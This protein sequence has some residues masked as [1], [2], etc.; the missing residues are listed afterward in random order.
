[1]TIIKSAVTTSAR[2]RW[3]QLAPHT[4]ILGDMAAI[5]AAF[6]L[7]RLSHAFYYHLNSGWVLLHWWGRHAQINQLLFLVLSISGI[8]AFAFKGHYSRRKAFWDETG[9][10]LGVFILL[11]ALNATIAFAG[12]W[13]MSRL[14]LF[15]TWVLV[16]G[17]LPMTRWLLRLTLQGLGAWTRPVVIIGCG[18]NAAEAIRALNSEPMLGYSIQRVLVP[19]GCS[20]AAGSLPTHAPIEALG[21]DPLATLAH[22]G[23]PHVVLA[24][25]MDQWE[26]QERLVRSLGLRYSNLTIA[27]P[28]RGLPLFGME[29]MHFFS[30]EVLMLRVRD[31]LARLSPRI[32]KRLFDLVAASLLVVV[33][34]PLLL[35]IA[36]RIRSE[37]G[38]PVFFI[39]ERVGRRG[40]Q[41]GCLKFRSMVMDAEDRLKRY[42]H[43]HPELAAE[44]AINF[45]I[46]NDPRVTRIG[47]FLR[48]GSLDEL[49]QLFNVLRGDMSLVGPRPLLERELDRYGENICLY[50]LVHPGITGLWQV[51]GRSETTFDER[52]QLDAWY[53]KN[54]TLW[55]DIVIL[56]RTVKVVSRREGAY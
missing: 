44:Y 30:H 49:P 1:M 26:A 8:M 35:Y 29:V 4:L 10:I 12:K 18:Q 36:W 46:R 41:F 45:K 16:L 40:R 54:W 52:A 14:W 33:L 38:G 22:L 27:P 5:L 32:T 37:D 47:K 19:G 50:R 39:Q 20:P 43:S 28:L 53:V 15:S 23:K 34:S 3:S 6:Y 9:E 48:R 51:S 2:S 24:L 21:E 7:G 31:N 42:L 17:F 56:L 55:Y 11:L 13:Q 25:D